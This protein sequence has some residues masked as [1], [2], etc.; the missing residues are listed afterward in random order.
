MKT[1]LVS[2]DSTEYSKMPT[3]NLWL[4]AIKVMAS[5][6]KLAFLKILL[7]EITNEVQM[8]AFLKISKQKLSNKTFNYIY[9]Y[10]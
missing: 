3:L 1:N 7:L 8:L 2:H 4:W 5:I 10:I 9:I 6:Q